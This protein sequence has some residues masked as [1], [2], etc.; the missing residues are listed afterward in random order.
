LY[1]KQ[2]LLAN[3]H[4]CSLQKVQGAAGGYADIFL[5]VKMYDPTQEK[6]KYVR[7]YYC[8]KGARQGVSAYQ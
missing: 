7:R 1:A 2:P 3:L 5:F 4:L 8:P 6:L